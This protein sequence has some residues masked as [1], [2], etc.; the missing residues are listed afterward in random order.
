MNETIKTACAFAMPGVRAH[1]YVT[2][3][4]N[5][6]EAAKKEKRPWGSP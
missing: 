5:P 1:L 3:V 2:Y 6:P 4:T